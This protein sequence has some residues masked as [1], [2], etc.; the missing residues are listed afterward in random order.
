MLFLTFPA[1]EKYSQTFLKICFFFP[2]FSDQLVSTPKY[3]T[4]THV[5]IFCG[6]F[7]GL[8]PSKK[9]RDVRTIH[10]HPFSRRE[11]RHVSENG[12]FGV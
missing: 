11:L 3:Q 5:L 1:W 10:L 4:E 2:M 7:E 6:F 12:G 8:D 9:M